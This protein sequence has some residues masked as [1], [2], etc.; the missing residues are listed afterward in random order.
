M[1]VP[2]A[3]PRLGV[4]RF[5]TLL[6]DRPAD[7]PAYR[8]LADQTRVLVCDGRLLPG[9]RLPSER[10]LS[11]TLGLSRTTVTRA[12]AELAEHGYLVP[13]Q[14]SGSTLTLPRRGAPTSV[15]PLGSGVAVSG[16][17]A[18]GAAGSGAL[19]AG[20]SDAG[21]A[22]LRREEQLGAASSGTE[23]EVYD[24]RTAAPA[25]APGVLA[26]F[27]QAV[28]ELPDYVGTAG[29][30]ATGLPALKEQIAARYSRRGLPT[31]PEQV[32][33]TSGALSGVAALFRALL[34][35]GER[36]VVETP[37]YPNSMA[38]L[39][40]SSA[41]PVG[42][43]STHDGLDIDV[44][45]DTARRSG[46]RAALLIP[47]F[48]NPTGALLD[49][50]SRALL[51]EKA[52]R[53]DLLLVADE[54]MADIHLESPEPPTPLAAFGDQVVL[55]GSASK[56][57]WGGLRLGWIRCS[58]D[59]VPAVEAA[60]LSLDL[61]VAVVEQ[62]ALTHALRRPTAT[63]ERLATL[64]AQRDLV[65][66]TVDA[67]LPGWSYRLPP[68]GLSLWCRLPRPEASALVREAARHGVALVPGSVFAVSG[69]GLEQYLRIPFSLSAPA[70]SVALER[71][72][73]AADRMDLR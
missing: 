31:T 73:A 7:E 4:G 29:Y 32:V 64:R 8:W 25:A 48:H 55:V 50:A 28:T 37:G 16:V 61:G 26:A 71:L 57:H 23:R 14:G 35:P 70:L 2:N 67:E 1:T 43:A 6:G 63:A 46:A 10:T 54:T 62:L 53:H 12:Y 27:Q 72:V 45:V 9:T 15:E 21:V 3:S 30:F 65:A 38:A 22:V 34:R 11:T 44:L 51:C 5:A 36:V 66:A 59:L 13:R 47:D 68:G 41:V 24:L 33:V 19:G 39:R 69:G 49:D 56:S 42:V 60:R 58:A 20:A 52:A 40:R 17:A 18:S